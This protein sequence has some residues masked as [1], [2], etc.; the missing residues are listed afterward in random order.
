MGLLPLNVF[1]I[2]PQ[3]VMKA[4]VRLSL[5]PLCWERGI[6]GRQGSLDGGRFE[7]GC[8]FDNA[9]GQVYDKAV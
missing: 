4:A 3:P 8:E 7:V 6:T 9:V 5:T 2:H 1:F